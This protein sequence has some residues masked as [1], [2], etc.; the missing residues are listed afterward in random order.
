MPKSIDSF[1]FSKHLIFE[2]HL[3]NGKLDGISY[4]WYESGELKAK[5]N[6]KDGGIIVS[7]K[8]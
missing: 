1:L 2:T 6:F 5:S 3:K 4:I 8:I 7:N